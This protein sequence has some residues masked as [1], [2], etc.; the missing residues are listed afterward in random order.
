MLNLKKIHH[1]KKRND[2]EYQNVIYANNY[3]FILTH[4]IRN[5]Q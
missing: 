4:F 2:D 5:N 1:I 3:K